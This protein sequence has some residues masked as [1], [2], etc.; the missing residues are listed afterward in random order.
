M[1]G[2]VERKTLVSTSCLYNN[3]NYPVRDKIARKM[4]EMW[5]EANSPHLDGRNCPREFFL[6]A[7]IAMKCVAKEL[8]DMILDVMKQR[9]EEIYR[10]NP[11]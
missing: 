4:W 10:N 2:L 1:L 11:E 8:D 3:M 7:E 6:M 9:L 5:V